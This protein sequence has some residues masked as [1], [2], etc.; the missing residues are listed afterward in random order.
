MSGLVECAANAL[1]GKA[2]SL[3][4]PNHGPPAEAAAGEG[5]R[6]D[7]KFN[8][9]PQ[10]PVRFCPFSRP[11]DY[12]QH[13]ADLMLGSMCRIKTRDVFEKKILYSS[14]IHVPV[15]FDPSLLRDAGSR[16]WVSCSGTHLTDGLEI[17]GRLGFPTPGFEPSS[18]A[19]PSSTPVE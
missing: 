9:S 16:R 8:M 3:L 2:E 17:T 13:D 15:K 10:A 11:C 19:L 1:P 14:Q 12:E 5:T 7:E 6:T 18:S 4:G